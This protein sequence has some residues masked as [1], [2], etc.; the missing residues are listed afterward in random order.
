[1]LITI[2]LYTL[3]KD[4]HEESNVFL[5]LFHELRGIFSIRFKNTVKFF[6]FIICK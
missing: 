6:N 5:K 3:A 1:M 4:L 2:L